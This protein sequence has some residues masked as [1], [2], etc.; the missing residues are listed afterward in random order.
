M[1][2]AQ[3]SKEERVYDG[4]TFAPAINARSR[5]MAI[6]AYSAAPDAKRPWTK[7]EAGWPSPEAQRAR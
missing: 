5:Q 1:E 4:C 3:L 2:Q 6:A 7:G